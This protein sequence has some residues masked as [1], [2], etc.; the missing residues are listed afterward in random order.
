MKRVL[1]L[2]VS[3]CCLFVFA[4]C[5]DGASA[6]S[7]QNGEVSNA[8]VI[9][10]E[11]SVTELGNLLRENATY[12]DDIQPLGENA[13]DAIEFVSVFYGLDKTDIVEA[14]FYSGSGATPEE[15]CVIKAAAGK[16]NGVKS[17][18]NDRVATLK[19]NFT[20]YNPEQM[21]KIDK[22]IVYVYG[23]YAVLSVSCDDT[24]AKQIIENY[25]E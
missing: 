14:V 13:T 15:I 21:P 25:F 22:A 7:S 10:K 11:Y 8:S 19:Q 4:S 3:F 20:D 24:Q 1:L 12:E 18:M 6:T 9:E 23:D 2:A 5:A 17:A 16:I